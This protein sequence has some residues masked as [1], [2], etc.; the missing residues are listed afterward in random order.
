M[1]KATNNK[2][3]KS[4]LNHVFVVFQSKTCSVYTYQWVTK[5]CCLEVL[6]CLK[7]SKQHPFETPGT[8]MLVFF[9]FFSARRL[10][11]SME[12]FEMDVQ[13]VLDELL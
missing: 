11:L 12:M 5:E 9:S 2:T 6:K 13:Q 3:S 8:M 1:S 4:R 7:T 10:V